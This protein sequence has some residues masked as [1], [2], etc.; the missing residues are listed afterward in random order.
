MFLTLPVAGSF[1]ISCLYMLDSY[2]RIHVDK[3]HQVLMK[4][5]SGRCFFRSFGSVELGQWIRYRST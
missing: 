2:T 4:S 3:T 5:Q 1:C